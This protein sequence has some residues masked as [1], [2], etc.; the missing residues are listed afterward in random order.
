M[1]NDYVEY[2][3]KSVREWLNLKERLGKYPLSQGQC[4]SRY[5]YHLDDGGF[6]I[7]FCARCGFT[8]DTGGVGA[9]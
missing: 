1:E 4:E 5:E 2:E 6:L 3:D 8:T 7:G 9:P